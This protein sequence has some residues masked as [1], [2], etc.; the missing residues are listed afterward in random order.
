[1]GYAAFCLW[2][3]KKWLKMTATGHCLMWTLWRKWNICAFEDAKNSSV[4]VGI[5]DD[6]LIRAMYDWSRAWGIIS[7][8]SLTD[9]KDSL[10]VLCT[11][12]LGYFVFY[13]SVDEI[14]CLLGNYLLIKKRNE[15]KDDNWTAR[16]WNHLYQV[17]RGRTWYKTLN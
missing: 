4:S 9:F 14:V 5:L 10:F 17:P 11:I 2:A 3:E 15:R 13:C 6:Y 8:N 1:M 7:N 16:T 12:L